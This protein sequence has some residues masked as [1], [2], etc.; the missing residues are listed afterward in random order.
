MPDVRYE[1]AFKL[2]PYEKVAAQDTA[3]VRHPVV[4]VGGGPIG[5]A[6]ALDLG[7]RGT[8]ALVLDDH[9]GVG[10]GSRAICFAKRTLEIA[11]RLGAGQAMLDKGVVWNVG[12]VFHGDSSV[13]DFNLLPEEGHA[14]PAFI[15]LQ[16]PY[17]E[18]FLVDQIR[19]EQA[20][21]CPH[22][23]SRPQ[24]GH[25]SARSRRPRHPRHQHPRRVLPD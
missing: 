16:Q 22:R 4:I 13:F 14:H 3:P 8:P 6:L 5:M 1:T 7:Q 24:S 9:D 19:V 25:R 12:R 11:D 2:Y 23:N 21:R 17:F 20:Q 18:K 15:N 10:L